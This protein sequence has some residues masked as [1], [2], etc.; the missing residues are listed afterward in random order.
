MVP[1]AYEEKRKRRGR[2]EENRDGLVSLVAAML[3]A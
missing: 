2:G 3:A 1:L